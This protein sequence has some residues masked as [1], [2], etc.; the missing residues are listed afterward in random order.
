MAY[1]PSSPGPSRRAFTLIELLVVISII[2]IL[3]GLA[4]P[5]LNGA[6]DAAKKVKAKNDVVQIVSAIKAYQTEYGKLPI[7]SEVSSG[8]IEADNDKLFNVLRGS[9]TIGEQG[10]MNPRR[11]P[12]IEIRVSKGAKDGLGVNDGKFYDPWGKP[13]KIWLDIDYNNEVE[14]MYTGG[15]GIVPG[16]AIAAS[17][18]KDQQGMTGAKGV[19]VT[20]D[21]VNSWQ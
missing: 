3:A 5:A 7:W 17:S 2:A 16:A 15:W 14:D 9:A 10:A 19:G 8:K 13:Y 1:L 20:K 4:F 6:I 12:F 18:G 11:I 21:D